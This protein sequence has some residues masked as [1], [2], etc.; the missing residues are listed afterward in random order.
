[1]YSEEISIEGKDYSTKRKNITTYRNI[2]LFLKKTI[3]ET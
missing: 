1:M 2:D 3:Y